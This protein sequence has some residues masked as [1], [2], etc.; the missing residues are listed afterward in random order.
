M[1]VEDVRVE[2]VTGQWDILGKVTQ[3]RV[4]RISTAICVWEHDSST[5]F[6][7]LHFLCEREMEREIEQRSSK[8]G[9]EQQTL[10]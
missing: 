3:H 2:A 4:L 5:V 9:K 6:L 1:I 10:S 7:A 8:T